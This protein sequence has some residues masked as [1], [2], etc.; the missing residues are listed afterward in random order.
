M[1][2]AEAKVSV[3]DKTEETKSG[4][5]PDVG[6][7]PGSDR[8]HETTVI[9]IDGTQHRAPVNPMSGAQLKA[10]GGVS[11]KY[12]LWKKVPGRDDLKIADSDSV[13]L[14]NGDHFYSAPSTL[15]PGGPQSC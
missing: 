6:N 10:L 2:S 11:N 7:Q 12:D 4:G 15:N 14:K 13:G 1:G 5:N 8:G 9:H 3:N